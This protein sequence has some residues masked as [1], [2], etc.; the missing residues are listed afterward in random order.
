[1][2]F[3]CALLWQTNKTAGTL[4]DFYADLAILQY[5]ILLL[6]FTKTKVSIVDAEHDTYNS[7]LVARDEKIEA[8]ILLSCLTECP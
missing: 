4:P 5:H 3:K 6:Q 2:V 7:N 1:M 8:K